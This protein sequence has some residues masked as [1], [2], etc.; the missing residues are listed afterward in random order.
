MKESLPEKSAEIDRV[1]RFTPEVL[2]I[3][4]VGGFGHGSVRLQETTI[5]FFPPN[6]QWMHTVPVIC[7]NA[8]ECIESPVLDITSPKFYTSWYSNMTKKLICQF[9]SGH[10]P[11]H[12][13]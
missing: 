10:I 13:E 8:F 2:E 7:N 5:F 11:R 3:F 1:T 6:N 12:S 4:W 9:C